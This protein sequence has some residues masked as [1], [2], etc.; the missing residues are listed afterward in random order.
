MDPDV[1]CWE[2]FNVSANV[3]FDVTLGGGVFFMLC[4]IILLYSY[5]KIR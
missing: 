4:V 1:G 5:H 3:I 2:E